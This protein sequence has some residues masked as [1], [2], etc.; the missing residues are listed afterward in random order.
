MT[1]I[2]SL[3]SRYWTQILGVLAIVIVVSWIVSSIRDDAI[4]DND[5]LWKARMEELDAKAKEA[6]QSISKASTNLAISAEK[7]TRA[8]NAQI[9]DAVAQIGNAQKP[10][11]AGTYVVPNAESGK[12]EFTTD[13]AKSFFTIRD[14]LP[15]APQ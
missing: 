15:K 2:L 3:L 8:Q 9:A 10:P 13:Y 7:S 5:T 4:E 12:C 1:I 14:S 11:P 6:I